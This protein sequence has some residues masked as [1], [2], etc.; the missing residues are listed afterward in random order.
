MV[1]KQVVKK[2][3]ALMERI[4]NVRAGM[5]RSLLDSSHTYEPPSQQET[6]KQ[7]PRGKAQI[8]T[9]DAQQ[10]L[11]T[12]QSGLSQLGSEAED[13]PPDALTANT[14][15]QSSSAHKSNAVT[16]A[17]TANTTEQSITEHKS[18]AVTSGGGSDV[19]N[20]A[21]GT[22]ADDA[23]VGAASLHEREQNDQE[24]T[25]DVNDSEIATDVMTDDKPHMLD[26]PPVETRQEEDGTVQDLPEPEAN[27][28]D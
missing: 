17:L 4:D 11:S 5:L 21:E 1:R 20:K 23:H 7:T 6:P 14:T 9:P 19:Q 10:Q 8:T 15:E 13:A 25:A 27:A 22:S 24:P 28:A 2:A 18:N 26:K 16:D 3:L 12:Q